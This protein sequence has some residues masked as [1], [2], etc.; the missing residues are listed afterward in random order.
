MRITDSEL[1]KARSCGASD[2]RG[3]DSPQQ[4]LLGVL[5]ANRSSSIYVKP[6][7]SSSGLCSPY[8]TAPN[9]L[10]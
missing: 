9:W 4:S 6:S 7:D 10:N 2:S 3:W 1:S 5:S 8:R